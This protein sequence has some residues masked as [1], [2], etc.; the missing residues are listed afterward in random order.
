[1]TV[2]VGSSRTFTYTDTNGNSQTVTLNYKTYTVQTAFGC[3]GIGE[4][5]PTTTSLVD[6]ITFPDGS[7]YHFT[8]EA[9]PNGSGN[10]TGRLASVTL[11]QGGVIRYTYSGGSNG[12]VCSDGSTAG[13]V[14]SISGD[15]GSSSST[16]TYSRS[17]GTGTSHT[18]V[19]DGLGNHSNYDFVEASN[20]PAGTTAAYYETHRNIY[21]GA[22]SGTPLVARQTCYNGSANPC[23]TSQFTLPISQI[24]TYETLNGTQ[25]HG[26]TTLY[27]TYGLKTQEMD[28]DFG[29]A[30]SRGSLLRQEV[31]KYGADIVGLVTEDDVYDGNFKLASKT[32]YSYDNSTLAA[33]SGVPQHVAVSG[34]R[35][36]LTSI[37]QYTSPT[38]ALN[39]SATYDD[40]GDVLST[41]TPNGTTTYSYDATRAYVSSFTLPT[42]S[43]GVVLSSALTTDENSGLMTG[44]TDANGTRTG[45]TYDSMLRPT[46]VDTF[47]SGGG[48][49]GKTTTTYWNPTNYTVYSYQ[50]ASAYGT[51]KAML[52]SYG[53]ASRSAV[54]N[55]QSS[56]SWY[57]QDAC[58]DANGNLSFQS[59]PYQGNG[60]S[61][62]KICSGNG[63]SY[64]YDALGR[65]T[66]VT[67]AD[68]TSV[69]YSYW[70]RATRITDENGVSRIIQRDGLGRI[71]A[72]CEM[73]S[74]SM[75]GDSPANCGTDISGTG[76]LTTYVYDLA[77]HKTTVTQGVQTRVFQ[78]DWVGRPIF[79]QEPE[80]GTTTYNYAYNNTGLVV[81]RQRPRANQTNPAVLTTTTT[82]YDALGRVL[83]ISYDDGTPTKYYTYDQS[84]VWGNSST[85]TG[86]AK[87]RVTAISSSVNEQAFV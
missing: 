39:I 85:S 44:A 2:A 64:S 87:G 32:T 20:A 43:S 21:Q 53:R 70:G 11:P 14:R 75:Q 54:A 8:Y 5:G 83:S 50:S 49:V 61:S 13:L 52:D 35:G 73:S 31:W 66:Q 72:V 74:K 9:T 24:D 38:T 3:S 81:T 19:T 30:S 71:T 79:V 56:N 45:F 36:N 55:G 58:Y 10:V 47:D 1:M 42:P 41:T 34:S 12:I 63:D 68:N 77:N 78:T 59:S 7:T 67:H 17:I 62:S 84:A 22:E 15:N 23:T 65:I 60:F 40:T 29:G 86:A 69:Q 82:Q 51:S 18:E 6:N 48:M 33:T 4:Y 25:Q 27:N 76:Y 57:Q 28:Y 37:Q 26:S 16:W 46:E 80:R